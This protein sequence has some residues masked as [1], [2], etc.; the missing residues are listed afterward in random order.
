MI[1]DQFSQ[2]FIDIWQSHYEDELPDE[3]VSKCTQSICKICGIEFPNLITA[4]TH[5]GGRAHTRKARIALE[6]WVDEDPS[7]RKLPVLKQE[8]QT[9]SGQAMPVT[10]F[11]NRSEENEK[12]CEVCELALSSK[13]VA[14]SVSCK[15]KCVT[16][17]L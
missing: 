4:R 8:A 12:Y 14:T 11:E 10:F 15:Q 2:S 3:I 5:Y 9:E 17:K 13:I 16:Y 1:G 6:M 7:N